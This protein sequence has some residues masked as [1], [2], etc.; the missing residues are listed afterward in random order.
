ME[1]KAGGRTNRNQ[2]AILLASLAVVW[3]GC[4]DEP[5]EYYEIELKGT[6]LSMDTSDNCVGHVSTSFILMTKDRMEMVKRLSNTGEGQKGGFSRARDLV[7]VT[8]DTANGC[9]VVPCGGGSPV[10]HACGKP[11]D[12]MV[13]QRNGR[14]SYQ[15]VEYYRGRD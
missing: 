8:M 15:D 12:T 4:F 11:V 9:Y 1:S 6:W 10:Y 2:I 13:I 3:T 5:K 7:I 14:L